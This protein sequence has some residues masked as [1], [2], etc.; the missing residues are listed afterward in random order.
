MLPSLFAHLPRIVLVLFALSVTFFPAH[1]A[2]FTV[3]LTITSPQDSFVYDL[4]VKDNMIRLE[5]T[6]GPMNVPSFPTIYNRS[7]GVTWGL[8]PQVQQYV[9]ETDPAKTMMMNPII[10]WEFMRRNLEV[11]PAG[12]ETIEGYSCQIFEYRQ[13]GD[14]RVANRVWVSPELDFTLKEVSYALNGDATLA[15]KNI[16]K[17][18]VDPA[19]FEIPPGYSKVVIEKAPREDNTKN[20][21]KKSAKTEQSLVSFSSGALVVEKSPEYSAD[22]GNIWMTDENPK[23]GW[24]CAGGQISNNVIVIELAE[25]SVFNR[26]EF[27]TASADG[28]GRGAKDILVELSDEGPADGFTKIASVTL[29]D[30]EDNQSFP[31]NVDKSG[32]WLRL[33]ILNNHG[34]SQYTELMDFR[35][36]G[37]QLTKTTIADVSGT[38][39]TNFNDFHLKQEGTSV[40]GCYEYDEGVLNGGIEDRIMKFI[41]METGQKGPVVMVFSSDG[42]KFYGIWWYEGREDTPGGTWNGVKIS[43]EV[44]GCAH[45]GGGVQEQMTSELLEFGRVRLYGI[46]FDFD[47]DIIRDESKPTLDKIVA[48]LKSEQAMQLIIEGHTDSDGSADHNQILSQQRAESVK[49]YLVSAGISPSRLFTKG[50]GESITVAPNTTA[51]GKA[52]NRRV[53]LVKLD[54]QSMPQHENVINDI[55]QI[56]IGK[57]HIAENQR[58]VTGSIIFDENGLYEMNE[59]LQD[60]AGVGKK[61]EYKINQNITPCTIDICLGQCGQEGSEWVTLFSILR[62]LTSDKIEIHISP[63]GNYP[64]A[65]SDNTTDKYTMILTRTE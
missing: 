23:T 28:A 22:W 16:K 26:L 58:T 21:A 17:G 39:T 57:W 60:G 54:T 59:K 29:V 27:D 48:M 55:S 4:K 9:E 15:L 50:Y 20:N 44:G 45:W 49:L 64:S 61:G 36:Y 2:Q 25:K 7:T 11:T 5:K 51:T 10:G 8:N 32:K 12:T 37:E 38:Y 40:T 41:W 42:E 18:P 47:S 3:D 6:K 43:D 19:L 35:A 14:T 33:T 1:A 56:I 65:F 34:D 30:R 52:Q 24:C 46:N 13:H 62:V 31:V 63:D 53:E